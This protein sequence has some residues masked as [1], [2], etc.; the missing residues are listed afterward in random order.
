M[1]VQVMNADV[2]GPG[3]S[4]VL[5]V[6]LSSGCCERRPYDARVA[7]LL[8]AGSGL[9][10]ME[11]WRAAE[12]GAEPFAPANPLTFS[13]GMLAATA[14]PC[15]S[16]LTVS[17]LS[18]LT[19][20]GGHSN[21][22][23]SPGIAL[24]QAG[25]QGVV[26]RG[27]APTP[28]VLRIGAYSQELIDASDLW[29][30][31]TLET[32]A[33]LASAV[34][35]DQKRPSLLLIGPGGEN[36]V[37]YA[38][39]MCPEGHA[40]GRTG[41]GAVMG[42]KRLKG[43]VIDGGS[44]D[45]PVSDAARAAA[46]RYLQMIVKAPTYPFWAHFGSGTV[47]E[48]SDLGMLTTR[49]FQES[50]FEYAEAMDTSNLDRSVVKRRGCPRCPI[51]CKAEMVL[52]SEAYA[53]ERGE[54]PEFESL[55]MWGARLGVAD[56]DAVVHLVNLCDRLGIDTD[57]TAA[58]IAF[59]IDL[60][61]RRVID[62]GDTDGLRLAWGDVESI[63]KL[64]RRIA[65]REGFGDVLADGVRVAALRIGRGAE[66]F[67][68]H[69]KGLE[70][71]CY[72]PRGSASVAL[73]FSVMNRGA[74]YASAYV[75][76]ED[77]CSTEKAER[78]YGDTAATDRY[79]QTGKASMV[80]RGAVVGAAL[81]ALGICKFP[82]LSLLNEYDLVNE[83]ELASAV[84]GAPISPEALF[85]V[86]ERTVT[87]NR[88]INVRLGATTDDDRLPPLFLETPL[89]DGPGAGKTA[90]VGDALLEYYER[91]GW[92]AEGVPTRGTVLRLGL[93]ELVGRPGLAR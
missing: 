67:A 49:N 86:G 7:E 18:P 23:G 85:A 42:S 37:R 1:G 32:A 56:G 21:V 79:L 48:T 64:T 82:A 89:R 22:G 36:R 24:R 31:D 73:A 33:L 28:V 74:D 26:V 50:T 13:C 69:V 60:F 14:A 9:G 16:R 40:A 10:S 27:A 46:R 8:L 65:L 71:P 59:A 25:L 52:T 51:R 66:D 88:L 57:S 44:T 43:V 17:A 2:A 30:L 93:D 3:M 78:L 41:M 80:W 75:R 92:S 63:E 54:R 61:E 19:G 83:A 38:S 45:L 70:I 81:D 87:L 12:S 62:A 4:D 5:E 34:P 68:Y 47:K 6:D 15:S 39:I 76:H 72:D 53:G 20:L 58:A 91:M 35:E 55:C 11:L 90:Q 84:T 29:G 77:D